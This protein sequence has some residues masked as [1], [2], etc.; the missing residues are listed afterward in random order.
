MCVCV[1]VRVHVCACEWLVE[2]GG[3][4]VCVRMC[5]YALTCWHVPDVYR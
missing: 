2:G 1:C 3:R 4:D 5:V